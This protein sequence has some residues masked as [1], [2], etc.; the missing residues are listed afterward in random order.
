LVQGTKQSGSADGPDTVFGVA[1]DDA[2]VRAHAAVMSAATTTLRDRLR[3]RFTSSS[4]LLQITVSVS[5]CFRP[6]ILARVP[7]P[8]KVSSLARTGDRWPETKVKAVVVV[9]ALIAK[10]WTWSFLGALLVWLAAIVFT[11][12]YGASGMITA[13]LSLAVGL[14]AVPGAAA[15]DAQHIRH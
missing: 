15:H 14:G 9:R 11:G 8:G 10:L 4:L 3:E 2:E 7:A 5:G 6:S 13:A 1:S 12:G